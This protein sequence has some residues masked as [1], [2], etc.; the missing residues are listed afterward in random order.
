MK[1]EH[2]AVGPHHPVAGARR[3]FGDR[4]DGAFRCLPPIE[5]KKCASRN[6]TLHHRNRRASSRCRP[7]SRHP[8]Y[9]SVQVLATH[10]TEVV[11]VAVRKY[12]T[13]RTD[14]PI[15]VA[16]WC[17]RAAIR[18]ARSDAC[19]PSNRRI[20]RRRKRILPRPKPPTGSRMRR[21]SLRLSAH[22]GA[23]LPSSR[24]RWRFR[25]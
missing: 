19:H 3:I 8:D 11:R 16:V 22:L 5:P 14:E 12:S 1:R 24:R 21:R 23:F 10:R 18:Q 4:D 17:R 20:S 25:R 13:I 15:A 9:R 2:S 6:A 7:A